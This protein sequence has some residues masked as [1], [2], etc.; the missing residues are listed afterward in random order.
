VT[1]EELVAQAIAELAPLRTQQARAE[2]LLLKKLPVAQ[3][4][5][6]LR[7]ET[8]DGL[9]SVPGKEP[10]PWFR[11]LR[12]EAAVADTKGW[13]SGFW[14]V[15]IG[16]DEPPQLRYARVTFNYDEFV[17]RSRG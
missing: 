10:S 6:I 5:A 7:E 1:D 17:K 3:A 14:R 15:L 11:Y 2:R 12:L 9:M 16:D 13:R 4:A 8:L